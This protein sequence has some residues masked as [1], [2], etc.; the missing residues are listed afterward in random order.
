MGSY[1]VGYI[2]IWP[3]LSSDGKKEGFLTKDRGHSAC[4][5]PDGRIMGYGYDVEAFKYESDFQKKYMLKNLPSKLVS[6]DT[7][8][9][10]PPRYQNVRR[11]I[12]KNIISTLLLMN[13]TSLQ[14]YT[15]KAYWDQNHGK[16]NHYT[17]NCSAVSYHA[18][19]KINLIST[20]MPNLPLAEI[21]TPK[22][23]M[24]TPKGVY[25]LL[26][27]FSLQLPYNY[28]QDVDSY[29]L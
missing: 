10:I 13:V 4:I 17:S 14:A 18:F 9:P 1:Q 7:E 8:P 16:Y 23:L 25:Y 24:E 12:S 6:L 22:K 21:I 15:F 11:A 5:L 2:Y 3:S 27:H 26:F 29:L 19:E 20:S 28:D